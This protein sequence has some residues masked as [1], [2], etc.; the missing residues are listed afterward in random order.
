MT[1]AYVQHALMT[2]LTLSI[3]LTYHWFWFF[4]FILLLIG[5]VIGMTPLTHHHEHSFG[6]WLCIFIRR[7][8]VWIG[9]TLMVWQVSNWLFYQ[10]L[11]H[12][13]AQDSLREYLIWHQQLLV[14]HAKHLGLILVG[15]VMLRILS[16]RILAPRFSRW[17]RQWRS[18]QSDETT[19]D[20][21]QE[22]NRLKAKSFTPSKHYR[23]GKVF[24]GLTPKRK[25]LYIDRETFI[26]TN[27]QIVG[28]TRYGKGL[29]LGTLMEQSILNGDTLFYID[30][31]NDRYAKHIL[32]QTALK[33]GRPFYY[34]SLD[35]DDVG[36]WGPFMGG[37]TEDAFSRL[38]MALGLDL[39]GD[40]GSDFYKTQELKVLRDAFLKSRRLDVLK[41]K[42]AKDSQTK[43]GAELAAW[44]SYPSL[45]PSGNAKGFSIQKAIQDNAIVYFKGALDNRIKTLAT[46]TFLVELLQTRRRQSADQHLCLVVDEVSFLVSKQLK[47]ALA[48]S[49][50]FGMNI[51]CAYQSPDDLLNT[52]D[53]SLN[54]QALLHSVN[55]NSQV[56]MVFGGAN[57]ELAKWVSDLSGTT[58]KSLTRA[59]QTS[60]TS[61]GA[62]LWHAGRTLAP[63][64]TPYIHPNVVLTLPKRM[65]IA[66]RPG[67][68]AQPMMVAPVPVQD[69]SLLDHY[70]SGR[71]TP[72]PNKTQREEKQSDA[73]IAD[74]H[75]KVLKEDRP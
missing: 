29:L 8:V 59:E 35:D 51:I 23:K 25:P 16:M 19:P 2:A 61:E 38:Q 28:P 46:K 20:I 14:F 65:C 55:V 71:A 30:P 57:A 27:T 24:F 39:K 53:M 58:T 17:L 47:D 4:V 75:N 44:A 68:L 43:A 7:A 49:L 21:T 45:C 12:M 52:D 73:S 26:E 62:E 37:T 56:K 60:I 9:F 11:D 74:N 42:F 6:Q 13:P 54:G 3:D 15:V 72:S 33:I 1:D 69:M 66:I 40:P 50:G 34:I 22:L 5:A 67:E 36:S 18:V 32:Y 70:L 64:E 48:T 10:M 31:K 63:V 41:D